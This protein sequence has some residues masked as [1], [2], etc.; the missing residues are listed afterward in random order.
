M[1]GAAGKP[2]RRKKESFGKSSPF[3]HSGRRHIERVAMRG[4][5]TKPAI[6]SFH[7]RNF[8]VDFRPHFVVPSI[9]RRGMK[10]SPAKRDRAG[11]AHHENSADPGRSAD[12]RQERRCQSFSGRTLFHRPAP[13]EHSATCDRLNH[14]RLLHPITRWPD[15]PIVGDTWDQFETKY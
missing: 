4:K 1:S 12:H 2:R 13:L 15:H 5:S 3:P 6:P 7:N 11:P 14:R 10:T 8:A 9:C